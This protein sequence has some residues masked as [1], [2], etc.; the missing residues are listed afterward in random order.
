M[1]NRNEMP[2]SALFYRKK[3]KTKKQLRIKKKKKQDKA[4]IFS[5]IQNPKKKHTVMLAYNKLRRLLRYDRV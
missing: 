2:Y 1:F 4:I 3:S 5:I